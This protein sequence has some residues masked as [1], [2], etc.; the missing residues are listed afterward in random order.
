MMLFVPE[1]Q[2]DKLPA[3]SPQARPGRPFLVV[4]SAYKAYSEALSLWPENSH[5]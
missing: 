1:L 4:Q 3:S 2:R 5:R